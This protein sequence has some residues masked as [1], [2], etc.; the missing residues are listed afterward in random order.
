MKIQKTI[1][2]DLE[3]FLEL[4]ERNVNISELVN[5]YLKEF[6]NIKEKETGKRLESLKSD[7]LK[8]E[9]NLLN[10]KKIVND[11]E[12]QKTTEEKERIEREG[13]PFKPEG[14]KE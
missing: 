14:W 10:K 11:L 8:I 5:S 9:T 1:T 13:V 7:I 6:L 4:K 3:V 12:V 2:I